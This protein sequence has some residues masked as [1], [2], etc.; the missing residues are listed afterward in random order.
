MDTFVKYVVLRQNK[1][2]SKADEVEFFSFKCYL[3]MCVYVHLDVYA[4]EYVLIPR[5]QK[6]TMDALEPESQL[7]INWSL[8]LHTQDS[9]ALGLCNSRKCS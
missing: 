1:G 3:N 8:H 9:R 5:R 6:T 7:V 4:T 2:K